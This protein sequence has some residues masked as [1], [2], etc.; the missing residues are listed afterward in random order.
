MTVRRDVIS[1][2]KEMFRKR[3]KAI[4]GVARHKITRRFGPLPPIIYKY[5][6]RDN[7]NG[8]NFDMLKYRFNGKSMQRAHNILVAT[9][10]HLMHD[11][12]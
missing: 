7:A 4:E 9:L 10:F 5:K 12:F 6:M 1:A 3:Y 8:T 11:C 2:A